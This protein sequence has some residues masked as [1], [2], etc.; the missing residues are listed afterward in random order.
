M[1]VWKWHHCENQTLYRQTQLDFGRTKALVAFMK[2][3]QMLNELHK[4]TLENSNNLISNVQS[5]LVFE[6]N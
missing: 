5:T 2:N 6:K 4:G 1:K 3:T